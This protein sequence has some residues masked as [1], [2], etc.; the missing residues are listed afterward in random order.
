MRRA[1]GSGEKMCDQKSLSFDEILRIVG[2]QTVHNVFD[3]TES[4]SLDYIRLDFKGDEAWKETSVTVRSQACHGTEPSTGASRL[5][6]CIAE[7][8][9]KTVTQR[10][11][12]T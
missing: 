5:V 10:N 4:S 9:V 12:S 2:K 3:D 8:I 7:R 1:V 11:V 6:V